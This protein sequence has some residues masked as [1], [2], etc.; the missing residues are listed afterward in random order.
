MWRTIVILFT[1]GVSS[2]NG[3]HHH[4]HLIFVYKHLYL[5]RFEE[6]LRS[7]WFFVH[8]FLYFTCCIFRLNVVFFLISII[9]VLCYILIFSTWCLHSIDIFTC[10]NI[11]IYEI[12][13]VTF[14]V[15]ENLGD[16]NWITMFLVNKFT[17][18]F[19]KQYDI[20]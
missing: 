11:S 20:I 10:K 9:R 3:S 12:L 18:S 8:F 1:L 5:L 16:C 2:G 4:F 17:N 7:K 13:I 14:I 15:L 19:K 6:C